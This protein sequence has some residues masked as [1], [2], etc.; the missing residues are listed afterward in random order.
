MKRSNVFFLFSGRAGTFDE[1]NDDP[2]IVLKFNKKQKKKETKKKVFKKTTKQ[3]NK[4]KEKPIS[5]KKEFKIE[6]TIV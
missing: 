6:L 2:E 1:N 3:T 5:P 4:K